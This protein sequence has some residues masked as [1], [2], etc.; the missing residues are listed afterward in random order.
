MKVQSS[1]QALVGRRSEVRDGGER[2]SH[3]G[4]RHSDQGLQLAVVCQR[5]RQTLIRNYVSTVKLVSAH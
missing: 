5:R 1:N 2:A 4:A 3:Q